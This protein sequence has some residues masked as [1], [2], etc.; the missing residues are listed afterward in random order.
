MMHCKM[1]QSARTKRSS[2]FLQLMYKIAPSP[3]WLY[4]GPKE[5]PS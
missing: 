3:L 1:R 5:C 4:K 2:K